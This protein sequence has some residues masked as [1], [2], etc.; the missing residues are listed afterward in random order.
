MPAHAHSTAAHRQ[1]QASGRLSQRAQLILATALEGVHFT[2]RAMM[3][4]IGKTDPN[5]V[6]PRVTEL[7]EAGFLIVTG[8]TRDPVTGK[9][10]RVWRAASIEE[11]REA[12]CRRHGESTPRQMPLL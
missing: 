12:Q 1:E 10:V 3:L 6:R 4:R 8:S 2:D 11:F 9:T 7:I 5:A